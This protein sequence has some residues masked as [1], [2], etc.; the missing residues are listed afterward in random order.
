M[1]TKRVQPWRSAMPRA[2]ANCQACMEEAPIWRALVQIHQLPHRGRA[3]AAQFLKTGQLPAA[4]DLLLHLPADRDKPRDLAACSVTNDPPSFFGYTLRDNWQYNYLILLLMGVAVLFSRRLRESRVGW[5]W[6][7]IR[8]DELAA[9]AM[10]INTTAAKL[11]AFAIGAAFAGTGGAFLA[12]WQRSVFPDNFLFTESVNILAMVILGGV[13][14]LPGVI[15]GATLIV[16]LPE[17]FRDFVHYRL[18]AFGLLLMVLMIFRPGGCCRLRAGVKTQIRR[19]EPQ[20]ERNDGR[21]FHCHAP[22]PCRSPVQPRRRQAVGQEDAE[23]S[24]R[25]VREHLRAQLRSGLAR[26]SCWTRRVL[27]RWQSSYRSGRNPA[28]AA[29]RAPDTTSPGSYTAKSFPSPFPR[30]VAAVA[31]IHV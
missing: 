4:G 11:Q 24:T 28:A 6:Q 9:Q 18:L 13:G 15:L 27:P 19:N 3:S 10:G 5:A 14:S 2:R 26:I 21:R 22:V 31:R 25:P 1:L 23:S 30:F 16:A 20:R 17:V 8:E 29:S 7:A 12:S